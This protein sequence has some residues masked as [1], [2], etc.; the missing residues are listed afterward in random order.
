LGIDGYAYDFDIALLEFFQTVIEGDQFG[1]AY[2]SEIERIEKDDRIFAFGE[3]GKCDFLDFVVAKYRLC[4]EIG[5]LLT[6]E[7]GHV[8]LL[9]EWLGEKLRFA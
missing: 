7:Y 2:E 1:R 4:G 8:D 9:K 3:L 6:Y 5:R